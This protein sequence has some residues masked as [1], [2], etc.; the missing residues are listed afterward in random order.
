MNTPTRIRVVVKAPGAKPETREVDNTLPALQALVG[1]YLELVRLN[2]EGLALDLYCNEEGRGLELD[3]N[4]HVRGYGVIL[5]TVVV[6]RSDE[7]SGDWIG[8]TED[9]ARA[10]SDALEVKA[11]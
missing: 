1:G 8:L 5:G 9:D 10:V 11:V 6:T 3:P 7:E 2:G 4:L